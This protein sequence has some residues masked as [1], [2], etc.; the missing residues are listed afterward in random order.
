MKINKE[1]KTLYVIDQGIGRTSVEKYINQIAF[2]GAE[3]FVDKYQEK[4][5]DHLQSI[6]G[7]GFL[8]IFYGGRD[9]F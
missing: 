2:S 1:T 6:I 4:G 7:H 9:F 8:F 5:K 3:E